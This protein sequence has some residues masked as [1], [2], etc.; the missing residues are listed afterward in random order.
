[1]AHPQH[2]PASHFVSLEIETPFAFPGAR[3]GFGAQLQTYF[4]TPSEPQ[5]QTAEV[6]DLHRSLPPFD[7]LPSVNQS[8]AW[9]T[10]TVAPSYDPGGGALN[11]TASTPYFVSPA[12]YDLPQA[13]PTH[14]PNHTLLKI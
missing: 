9:E 1:M 3:S 7:S 11:L 12:Q 8:L 10:D 4:P 2:S 6:I 14:S 5:A 13:I